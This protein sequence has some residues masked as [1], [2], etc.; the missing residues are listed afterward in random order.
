M[1]GIA[2]WF[3]PQAPTGWQASSARR[4]LTHRGPDANGSQSLPCGELIHTRLK[5][6][7][8]SDAGHQPMGTP[9]GSTWAVFNGEIYNHRELRRK[10]E[11]RGHTFR[12]RCDAEVLV[13]LYLEHGES[14]VEHLRGMFAIAIID[15]DARRL[16]LVR[17]RF[18]IKPLYWAPTE[19]GIVF[20]SEIGALR[21]AHGVDF[22][23]NPQA[24]HDFISLHHIPPPLT[25][26]RGV[27]CLEPGVLLSARLD[28][29]E[30]RTTARRYHS[31]VIRTD[32]SMTL[33]DATDRTAELLDAAVGRQLESDVPLGGM[34]SGGVDSALICESAHRQS[35]TGLQTFGVRFDDPAF[36]EGPAIQSA[37]D[38]IQSSHT[39]LDFSLAPAG[40]S[41]VSD[42]LLATGQPFAD[43]S[44]FAVESLAQLLRRHVAVALSGDG[45]DEAFGGYSHFGRLYGIAPLASTPTP[46][47][48]VLLRTLAAASR[49][50]P[51]AIGVPRS[52]ET[53]LLDASAAT[54]PV[55]LIADHTSWVR[56]REMT[57][58]WRGPSVLPTE[59]L[60]EPQWEHDLGS[61]RMIDRLFAITT[62]AD[63]RIRLAG[64]Y[65]PKVDIASMRHSLE[66]RVPMLDE[67]L[68][69]FGLNL[70]RSLRHPRGG[71]SKRVLRSLAGRRVPSIA[72]LPKRGFGVP[73]DTWV[74]GDF[75]DGLRDVVGSPTA[76]LR[77]WIDPS[78][79]DGLVRAFCRGDAT[80][81]MTRQAHY[82]RIVMLTAL[83]V[84]LSATGVPTP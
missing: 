69:S 70:P 59:R 26:H 36:D 52:L 64:D 72:S 19:S 23:V 11:A 44:I 34:L 84:H 22:S 62:E 10:L 9:G 27:H 55:S 25:L 8:L 74:S 38:A 7:D 65:L 83:E 60:F 15:A 50:A 18:G 75:R 82:Q 6:V 49:R 32:P 63:T 46:L 37:A 13:P 53:R 39:M 20:A 67:D 73:V 1:C 29:E 66:V 5:I 56:S 78:Y 21:T 45:G 47:R 81:T 12:G 57:E 35:A 80:P 41:S 48:Q 43:S 16:L 14:F 24:V 31:W 2:G 3:G 51:D 33:D 79:V 28:R 71:P 58:L 61:K 77:D 68:F 4:A 30:T 42:L 54:S 17:D 40:W 76:R